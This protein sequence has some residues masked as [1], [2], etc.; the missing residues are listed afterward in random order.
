MGETQSPNLPNYQGMS[1]GIPAELGTHPAN[2]IK[3]CPSVQRKR[4]AEKVSSVF[5]PVI[6]LK[7][8]HIL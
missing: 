1:A 3:E 8:L 4:V 7:I 5:N 2:K 6:S